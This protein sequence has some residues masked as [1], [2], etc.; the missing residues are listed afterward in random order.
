MDREGLI[1][2]LVAAL[3][4]S[5][6][7]IGVS[8]SAE[9]ENVDSQAS[10]AEIG[11]EYPVMHPDND[12]L[13]RW[14]ESYNAAPR[15]STATEGFKIPAPS[16]AH[17]VLSH[18]DY[19]P[20]E[21]DQGSCGNCWAWA[22]TGC[23]EVAL[24]VEN[25]VHDRLSIQ[26]LNSLYYDGTGSEYA[27]CGGWLED[28]ADFYTYNTTYAIPWANTNAEWQDGGTSCG[29]STTVP[30]ATI[31]TTPNYPI[32]KI[33]E[34]AIETQG[35]GQATAIANIKSVLESDNA[36]WFGFVLPNDADWKDFKDFWR[37]EPETAI[38]DPGYSCGHTWI[39][40]EG[41][42][43]AVLCVGYNDDD[44]D[45]PYWVMLNSWGTTPQRPNGLFRVRMNID[46]NCTFYYPP[47]N[48]D[49]YSLYW[50]MLDIDFE[51][52]SPDGCKVLFDES[53]SPSGSGP[54]YYTIEDIY[55]DW[56]SLLKSNG[57]S[58][59]SITS[60]PITLDILKRYDVVVI[61]EPTED[62]SDSEIAAIKEYVENG[63]GLLV[64]GEWG[65]FATGQGIYPVVNEISKEFEMAFNND[66]VY[67][68]LHN[69]GGSIW[70]IIP[71]FD[72]SVVGS[73]VSDVVEYATC[74]INTSG[75][76]FPIAWA[77]GNA[78]TSSTKPP[79]IAD[80]TGTKTEAL[81]AESTRVNELNTDTTDQSIIPGSDA[82]ILSAP[83]I[84]DSDSIP[85]S[86]SVELT[87]VAAGDVTSYIFTVA[88]VIFFSYEDGTSLKLY[89][90]TGTLIWS[91]LLDKGKHHHETVPTGVYRAV[92]SRPFAVLTGDPVTRTVCG[93]YAM[94]QN[95]Y[96][97]STELYTWVPSHAWDGEKFIIFAYED[98]TQVKLSYTD[99]GTLIWS[100]TLNRGE[101]HEETGI[102]SRYL[103]IESSKPVSALTYFDQGYFVPSASKTFAGTKFYTYVGKVGNWWQDLTVMA[104]KDN[105]YVKIHDTDTG[106][107]IWSGNLDSGEAHVESFQGVERYLTITSRYPVTVSVQPWVKF[108]STYHE[109]AY[110]QDSTGSGIGTDLIGST[111]DGGYLYIFAFEDGTSVNIYNSQTGAH[112]SS[113]TLNKGDYVQANPGNGLWRIK[114]NRPVSA[115]SGYGTWNADFAPVEFGE[116]PTKLQVTADPD[117]VTVGEITSVDALVEDFGLPVKNALVKLDGCGVSDSGYTGNNGI[118]TFNIHP[119]IEGV[120]NVTATKDAKTGTAEIH[121][122]EEG[123]VV[124][125]ASTHGDGRVAL[126]GDGN[127][128]DNSDHDGDSTI[129]LY[130]YEN[131]KLAVNIIEW[132]CG[133][134]EDLVKWSQPPDMKYGVNIR[135]TEVEPIVADDWKCV[136]PRP[137]T[138][139]H[140]WGSYINWE[141]YNPEPPVDTPPKVEGFIIRIYEDVPAGVDQ[142]YSH[143]GKLLYEK[144]VTEFEERYVASIPHL[145]KTF[146][147][148]F[149]YSLD[150]PEPFKQ[151]EGT[152]YW[153]SIAAIMPDEYE[154]KYPWGWETS[155]DHWNDNACR[156]WHHNDYW[157]EITPDEM[158][159]WYQEH[160]KTVDMA[161][162]LT[163]KLE[164]EL[165]WGDAPDG[166]TAAG[167]PTLASSNGA[168]HVIVPGFYLGSPIRVSQESSP[169][170]G[171]FDANLIGYVS[172][173]TTTKSTAGYYQYGTPYGAS[174]NGPAPPLTSNRSHLFLAETTDGLS[175]FVVHDKPEDGSGGITRMH[176]TLAGDT[177]G[178]LAEDDPGE[179][180]TVSGGGTIFDSSHGWA[181]CCTDG[182]AFGS[183]DGTWTITGNFTNAIAET[184]MSEWH[185]YSSDNS[186]VPLALETGRRVRLDNH[187][188]IDPEPDGQPDPNALGDDNDG[189][190]D[191]DGV[192]FETPLL[193]GEQATV[194]ITASAKGI[195]QGW[196]DFNSDWDW[197]DPGE[198]IFLNQALTQGSNT[199]TFKV[200]TTATTGATFARFRFSTARGL[201]FDGQAPDGEVEDYKVWIECKPSIDV[202]KKVFDPETGE[203]MDAITADVGDTVRFRI[204]VHND[205]TCCDL[206]N[207]F[208][209]DT[210]S[211]S[212][213]YADNAT[214]NGKP[215][216]PFFITVNEFGWN[217][218]DWILEPCQTITI[219]FDA[220]V[221]E[222]GID[223]NLAQVEAVC[224]D[225]GAVLTDEDTATVMAGK[226]E[227]EWTWNSTTVEPSYNQVM[228]AP[229]VADLN[230]DGIPDVI[231]STYKGGNYVNDGIL[232]AISGD[233]SGELFSVTD[234]R[235]RVK[236]GAEPAVA[237]IDNDGKPEIMVSKNTSEIICFE[238]DGSYK[239]TSTSKVGR[240]AVAVADL[241]LDGT[242]EIIAGRTVF[243]N[244]GTR[245]WTG[246]AGTSYASAVADLDLD[247][248]PE[249]VTGSAAYRYDGSIYWTSSHGGMPAIGN[250]DS[251]PYPEIVV[252]GGD[253]VSL[254]EHDGTLKW[255]PIPMPDGGG[256]GPPLVAD[257]DGDG[258]PEIGVGGRLHYVT[259]ETNGSIKWTAD[260]VDTSSRAAGSSAFDFDQDG[261]YEIIYSDH[262]YHRIYKGSDGTVLYKTPGP[263]GTLCEQPI[264]ADVDNDGH[265]E[266]VFAVNNYAFPGNTGI[267][268]YGND[269]CW[270]TARCIWNQHTYHI[271][272]INDDATVPIVETNN[273][274]RYNNYRTQTEER[275]GEV[276]RNEVYFVPQESIVDGGYCNSADVEIWV[277]ATEFKSGQINL[278]Y[279]S[280]CAN[281]TNYAWNTTN[282]PM[283]G[284]THH[285]GREWITFMTSMPS[286]TGN[287]Q[288][289]TL[290]IHC[291]SDECTTPLNFIEGSKLFDPSANEIPA[292]WIDGTFECKPG[293]C[294]DVNCDNNV[295]MGDV[296]LLHNHVQYGYSIC[297]E[298][299]GDVN[300]DGTIDMG[301]VGLL[302]N[303]VQYEY[304]LNCC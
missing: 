164:L 15:I 30:A 265:A 302:H 254:K 186:S 141:I 129:S 49:Y 103:H 16:G 242:P 253:N 158:P 70:P 196:I 107:L 166:V 188:P 232:R 261:S 192:V 284:W 31:S 24:D 89:N 258:E 124:M 173:Y 290:T 78:Y 100:G 131:E 296:G 56:A 208:V 136:D 240:C 143:P 185:V 25:G 126:I 142:R 46:Y 210:L 112:V 281:V 229:V 3:L 37:N 48:T 161:F 21:R 101:H 211:D 207:T 123:P 28:L 169:G 59:N 156:H 236:P 199:L 178:V 42:G 41:G 99:T 17:S 11:R 221:A 168:R 248:F 209:M 12:T 187:H 303:H 279:N 159:S 92:G 244:D 40:G 115:Y 64:L 29:W 195:L 201:S 259:F 268:V 23:M 222:C 33:Q 14:I 77:Y 44:P 165:D 5:V 300:C 146:E 125:A 270:P 262:Y 94:D 7:A 233:G 133:A 275:C 273:W 234:P 140:F 160:Y 10:G 266:L 138:D 251:D 150:L 111:I 1:Y 191:E 91:G 84:P 68:P 263:S 122:Y 230:D 190:D 130:E 8:V 177:A 83:D 9:D 291:E 157:E 134:E 80:V 278:S 246:A 34:Y 118:A 151:R 215:W 280:N 119:T 73:D 2:L 216:E 71:D 295:D 180:V 53:H 87:E 13:K 20:S 243:N 39:D 127:L 163:V 61:P 86:G 75:S 205:G 18:I 283:S 214:V 152:I 206:T 301:D 217:L 260:I 197:S 288:I 81:E 182:M 98:N 231:F 82:T 255:G 235:Y 104:Y 147:H 167:Y 35:V 252:V 50:Q 172:P 223:E 238:N 297:S 200:P 289:G 181:P 32:T 153:I 149:Y 117:T 237:D 38:W 277:N 227:L 66:T 108:T 145:D 304:L 72:N 256:N 174:F 285:D 193:P 144:K 249:V 287:Y 19:V 224:V 247:G 155:T 69:D 276:S 299:A 220:V 267:E 212:L 257:I 148:K 202:E 154:Y 183:L 6:F 27:C 271:T 194:T 106:A 79:S 74:S 55:S 225:T 294:G 121:V 274:E 26:Y 239:W 96:G 22:G 170:A 114:S 203:W 51:T 241:D 162:E 60:G 250:F 132:L 213:K 218:S 179:T 62:Y 264:I 226:P 282:F 45:N 76:A 65:P 93:Y 204:T 171:D 128:F 189:N 292:N 175:L 85:G 90:S 135:S 228:M 54:G 137:V 139:L 113:H 298:W 4:L 176:W 57:M 47:D 110:V 67:D 269:E 88:D 63:G 109:G 95:G 36:V 116:V 219:E 43:H 272:N 97:A 120:I 184:G 102:Y 198:Q 286:L 52:P 105:T 245:R 58:V 293:I